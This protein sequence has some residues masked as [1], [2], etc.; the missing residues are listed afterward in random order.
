MSSGSSVVLAVMGV[1]IERA[2]VLTCTDGTVQLHVLLA[3]HDPTCPPVL[4]RLAFPE[5]GAPRATHIAAGVRAAM[6]PEGS[7]ALCI[8]IGLKPAQHEGQAVLRL[9][10]CTSITPA[11]LL[12]APY[13]IRSA[14]AD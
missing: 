5:R 13:P 7:E 14:H 11:D 12:V 6:L 9:V 4:A 8:G 3:Q 2:R 1:L 10:Q